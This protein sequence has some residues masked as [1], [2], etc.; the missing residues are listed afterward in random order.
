ML[1]IASYG[2]PVYTRHR[3]RW[4]NYIQSHP[5]VDVFFLEMG[6]IDGVVGDTFYTKGVETRSG[7]IIKTRRALRHFSGYDFIV[8]TNLSSIWN[9]KG[10]IAFLNT[11]PITNVYCGGI[12]WID[13]MRYVSGSGIIMTPDV[14]KKVAE[15]PRYTNIIDDV[16]IGYI[17][18]GLSIHPIPYTRIDI[19]NEDWN[20][21]LPPDVFH[22]RVRFAKNRYLE[23]PIASRI[24]SM[25]FS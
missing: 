3:S 22:V 15:T 21:S 2:E 6:L 9:F 14:A 12:N 5:D 7:I 20:G 24:S 1:V 19:E 25:W 10:L 16:D 4:M 23:I 11:L 13:G 18:R 8:R 17:M